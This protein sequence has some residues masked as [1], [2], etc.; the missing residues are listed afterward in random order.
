[1]ACLNE[2][3]PMDICLRQHIYFHIA[4]ETSLVPEHFDTDS[5]HTKTTGGDTFKTKENEY[6]YAASALTQELQT[7]VS[8]GDVSRHYAKNTTLL[9]LAAKTMS[10]D[11]VR[12]ELNIYVG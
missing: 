7:P 4:R 3:S 11:V 10:W 1:M 2:S 5:L 9:L 12:Q 8:V 6:K